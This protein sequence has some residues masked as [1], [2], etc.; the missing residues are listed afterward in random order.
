MDCGSR[1]STAW[2]TNRG[3]G[4]ALIVVA[5][6]LTLG[7]TGPALAAGGTSTSRAWM[8]SRLR[9]DG[10]KSCSPRPEQRGHELWPSG[11]RLRIDSTRPELSPGR[12]IGITV[13]IDVATYPADGADDVTLAAAA[14]RALGRAAELGGNRTVLYS[15]PEGAPRGWALSAARHTTALPPGP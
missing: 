8:T 4:I 14:E 2:V 1:R 15:L 5:F 12:P 11:V 9:G 7:S 10:S 6:A 3:R 13:S